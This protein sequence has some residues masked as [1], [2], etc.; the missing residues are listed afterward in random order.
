M[1]WLAVLAGIVL[2][3][4]IVNIF[5]DHYDFE[6]YF[7]SSL[8][9]STMFAACLGGLWLIMWASEIPL[10]GARV[11]TP[12]KVAVAE[13]IKVEEVDPLTAIPTLRYDFGEAAD[14]GGQEI[15]VGKFGGE[16]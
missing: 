8:F 11:E 1:S 2:G 14:F 15:S 12:S 3:C 13:E 7:F 16:K 4:F 6:D 9:S 5:V 10:N